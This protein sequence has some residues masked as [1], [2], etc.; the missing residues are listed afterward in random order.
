MLTAI[1]SVSVNVNP[2]VLQALTERRKNGE[3]DVQGVQSCRYPDYSFIKFF[4]QWMPK[5]IPKESRVSTR[6]KNIRNKRPTVRAK[7]SKDARSKE[8]GGEKEKGQA[9]T[10]L[11]SELPIPFESSARTSITRAAQGTEG[12]KARA[13]NV[14][15]VDMWG[16][17]DKRG[18]RANIARL[19][20]TWTSA[21]LCVSPSSRARA[22]LVQVNRKGKRNS[23]IYS[24]E[25]FFGHRIS[26]SRSSFGLSVL[27]F[28]SALWLKWEP[29]VDRRWGWDN[30]SEDYL[31]AF[32]QNFNF[33]RV[34][35][36]KI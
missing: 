17:Q 31:W 16:E 29:R 25:G 28:F 22:S 33:H 10:E 1:W 21:P 26:W 23:E 34:C 35:K 5:S 4:S 18:N 14:I 12:E 13:L 36:R 15:F 24:L 30:A 11:G 2:G 3:R 32:Y 7:R 27:F 20:P 8:V 9:R 19:S 6:R